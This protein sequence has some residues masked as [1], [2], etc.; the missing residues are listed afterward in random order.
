MCLALTQVCAPGAALAQQVVGWRGAQVVR[1]AQFVA[2]VHAWCATWRRVPGPVV[3]IYFDDALECAAALYG[4]WHAGKT[5]VLPGDTQSASLEHLLAGVDACAG[6]LPGALQPFPEAAAQDLAPLSLRDT[7]LVLFTSGSSGAPARIAKCLAQLDAEVQ[8]LHALFGQRFETDAGPCVLA[9]VSH[10]HIY[11]LLFRVLWP[12]AAGLPTAALALSY[13]EEVLSGLAERTACLL[14]SSPAF[15]ARL[16]AHL[17][18]AR[19]RGS[20][21]AVFSSGGPLPAAAS[22]QAWQL[23]AKSPTEVFGSSETGGIAWRR[24]AQHG[25]RWNLLPGIDCRVN[26]EG[27]LEVRSPHLPDA[28]VWWETSD[29]A[30]VEAGGQ[31]FTLLGR[32]DRIVKI[33]EK[34][35]SL[36]AMEHALQ[37]SAWV[38]AARAVVLARVAGVATE[39]IG[40]VVALSDAG[41]QQLHSEGRRAMQ[42]ALRAL[43]AAHVERVALPRHWRYVE[44]LPVNAQGKST[45]QQLAQLFRPVL[46]GLVWLQRDAEQAGARWQV[47]ADL[48]VFDGHFPDAPLVPGVAQL[49]W[50]EWTGRQAFAMPAC[51]VRAEVLKFQAPILPG[52]VVEV[53]LQWNAQKSALQFALSSAAGTH[54][55][56]RLIWSA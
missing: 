8:S 13:P 52:A 39:R 41:W 6:Q 3:A 16:P 7:R 18:W 22:E 28:Q 19:A 23:L 24:R 53:A 26:A 56:G 49:H 47:D 20:L 17:D 30:Q 5:V 12:L 55:S 54:A 31:G 4:A 15:L 21:Q 40:M 35:V 48:L 32:A 10:Q 29:R 1:R 34:R 14:V 45:Q 2:Q 9:T 46:P 11:G 50:V 44:S 25:E 37:A 33:A 38:L 43:V 42:V 27:V 36:T 51:F